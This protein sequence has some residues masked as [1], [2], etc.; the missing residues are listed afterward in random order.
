MHL[1]SKCFEDSLRNRSEAN[2]RGETH[3]A[4]VI[5]DNISGSADVLLSGFV[6]YYQEM[7]LKLY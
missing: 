4:L 1:F 3:G 7:Q 6:V 2:R 5:K